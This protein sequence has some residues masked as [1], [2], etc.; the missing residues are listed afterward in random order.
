L[1]QNYLSRNEFS[2]MC[3]KTFGTFLKS[4]NSRISRILLKLIRKMKLF[5]VFIRTGDY[6]I[7]CWQRKWDSYF[8]E[9]IL[10]CRSWR[11]RPADSVFLRIWFPFCL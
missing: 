2:G 6:T 1:I 10:I 11:D 8:F 4:T 9:V 3:L 5:S 7:Q